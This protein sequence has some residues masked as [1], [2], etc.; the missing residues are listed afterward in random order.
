MKTIPEGP[1]PDSPHHPNNAVP[2]KDL[3]DELA[4]IALQLWGDKFLAHK[5]EERKGKS[6]SEYIGD[7]CYSFADTMIKS[8]AKP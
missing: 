6:W 3:R 7:S 8:R 4:L 2:T 1:D 5:E